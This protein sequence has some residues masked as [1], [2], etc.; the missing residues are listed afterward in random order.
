MKFGELPNGMQTVADPLAPSKVEIWKKLREDSGGRK[1]WERMWGSKMSMVSVEGLEILPINVRT[2]VERTRKKTWLSMFTK[3]E[4]PTGLHAP[5][6][7][8][9]DPAEA[10]VRKAILAYTES[11]RTQM[12]LI[13]RKIFPTKDIQF[14]KDNLAYLPEVRFP[15]D[16]EAVY[17]PTNDK[18]TTKDETLIWAAHSLLPAITEMVKTN[19]I[20]RL[21]DALPDL[22]PSERGSFN[23]FVNEL[24]DEPA[25]KTFPLGHDFGIYPI[26]RKL[27]EKYLH[28]SNGMLSVRQVD[29]TVHLT[30]DQIMWKVHYPFNGHRIPVYYLRRVHP[31]HL[32][33]SCAYNSGHE[34]V[35]MSLDQIAQRIDEFKAHAETNRIF[36]TEA[37]FE[38]HH[39]QYQSDSSLHM[40]QAMHNRVLAE[41]LRHGMDCIR[42]KEAPE[43]ADSL[44]PD[45]R[46]LLS[47]DSEL[48]KDLYLSSGKNCGHQ[49]LELSGQMTAA[50]IDPI[51]LNEWMNLLHQPPAMDGD[52]HWVAARL[53]VLLL[54]KEIGSY[55]G[56][57]THE[58][59]A[60][61][62]E[63]TKHYLDA[64]ARL[65]A[66]LLRL[67]LKNTYAKE[68]RVA[69]DESPFPQI[70]AEGKSIQRLAWHMPVETMKKVLQ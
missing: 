30:L 67:L 56:T 38:P 23:H 3:K 43:N 40:L 65:Q 39:I 69:I 44:V 37:R 35:H 31:K 12:E 11:G 25:L 27:N 32:E 20:R 58:D 26:L 55:K 45:D 47:E 18:Q 17:V 46:V 48:K 4:E 33:V 68:F 41:E 51:V 5:E 54:A 2:F 52:P 62:D 7:V 28:P 16:M 22:P 1:R 49:I 70:D 21:Q 42:S 24:A 66:P 34:C 14:L 15:E 8:P 63:E 29:D 60:S 13:L 64:I 36:G 61:N 10:E 57:F 50:C 19:D 53:A 9:V 59:I 6:G